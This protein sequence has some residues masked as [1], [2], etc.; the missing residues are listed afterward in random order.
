[1]SLPRAG[2][3]IEI[4]KWY[5]LAC[6]THVAPRAG[7]WIEIYPPN[8]CFKRLMVAPR[9]GAWIEIVTEDSAGNLT[10]SRSP[11]GSVD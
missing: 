10:L 1:M 4:S 9:A 6:S 3:W 2:A 5:K 8:V 11:C 7:A